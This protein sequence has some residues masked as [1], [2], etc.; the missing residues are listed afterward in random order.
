MR[1]YKCI[2]KTSSGRAA[3]TTR[4]LTCATVNSIRLTR[5]NA[6]KHRAALIRETRK[7][8]EAGKA[9]TSEEKAATEYRL[10][11]YHSGGKCETLSRIA[12]AAIWPLPLSDRG[13]CVGGRWRGPPQIRPLRS[14]VSRAGG[15]L[16]G[17]CPGVGGAAC[18]SRP[19]RTGRLGKRLP[20]ENDNL[21]SQSARAPRWDS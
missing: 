2:V 6:Q 3:D 7:K 13:S 21:R 4:V 1:S 19:R 10:F 17:C 5:I 11:V 12:E 14:V 8:R 9:K 18:G 20:G 16:R 15:I